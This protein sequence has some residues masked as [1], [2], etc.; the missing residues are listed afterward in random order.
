MFVNT[1]SSAETTVTLKET[2]LCC[3]ACV[4]SVATAI[5]EVEGAKAE[6]D[7][8]KKTITISADSDKVAR[9]AL[10]AL[11]KAGFHGTSDHEKLKIA[12]G[13]RNIPKGKV[14]RIELTGVHNCCGACTKAIK[15]VLESVEG[16]AGDTV[17]A[18]ESS[19][20]V[21]GD[22]NARQL[23]RKLNK[24]GF[25]ATPKKDDKEKDKE[26]V[27]AAADNE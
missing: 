17:K 12:P 15:K 18:K 16:V 5:G 13:L 10:T 8:E 23:V 7:R 24:A 11:A 22:F 3:P 19:F 9:Q 20:V 21:E 2:H 1:G 26:V 27:K 25:H 14:S 4:K 6:C